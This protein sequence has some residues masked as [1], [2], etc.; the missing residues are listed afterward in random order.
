[1]ENAKNNFKNINQK[2]KNRFYDSPFDSK[3]KIS[4]PITVMTVIE[5]KQ[6][7]LRSNK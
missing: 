6:Q 2:M 4:S 1:M 5:L 3:K 7:I